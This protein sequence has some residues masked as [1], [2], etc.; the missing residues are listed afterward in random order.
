LSL[1]SF[2]SHSPPQPYSEQ[3]TNTQGLKSV[4]W[5]ADGKLFTDDI[6]YDIKIQGET[7]W[8]RHVH[9]GMALAKEETWEARFRRALEAVRRGD[10]DEVKRALESLGFILEQTGDPN[11]WMYYH[12]LLRGDPFFRHPRNLISSP[13][14]AEKL[15]PN[16]KERPEPSQ[17][18]DSKP[19]GCYGVRP[20]GRRN[21]I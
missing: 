14:I 12:P 1:A 8:R 6:V 4:E 3:K 15:R 9:G 2:C 20:R 7:L 18:N 16:C 13:R 5:A 17:T 21:W 19:Q 11:H 10:F